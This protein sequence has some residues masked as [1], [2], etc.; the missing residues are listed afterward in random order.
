MNVRVIISIIFRMRTGLPL[1]TFLN[2]VAFTLGREKTTLATTVLFTRQLTPTLSIA[3]GATR[4]PWNMPCVTMMCPGMLVLTVAC[5][6]LPL[7]LLITEAWT[8]WATRL[9]IGKFSENVG[10]VT[11]VRHLLGLMSNGMSL[12]VFGSR[13]SPTRSRQTSS[14]F[15]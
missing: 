13:V 1:P 4:V 3:I 7:S 5:I 14:M 12:F 2:S 11:C 8:T 10:T 15:S 6:Q 9:V